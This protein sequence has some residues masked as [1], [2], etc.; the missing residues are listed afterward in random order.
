MN[1]SFAYA[2]EAV[3]ELSSLVTV[4]LPFNYC[5][6][7]VTVGL[8]QS[9]QPNQDSLGREADSDAFDRRLILGLPGPGLEAW[10]QMVGLRRPGRVS[11]PRD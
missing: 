11:R 8:L 6:M 4:G 5:C 9:F 7:I 10:T 2:S 3:C 1:W